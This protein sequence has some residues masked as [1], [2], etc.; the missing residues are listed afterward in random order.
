MSVSRRPGG[1]LLRRAGDRERLP[2]PGEALE[3]PTLDT[4]GLLLLALALA[5]AAWVVPSRRRNLLP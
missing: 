5:L 2:A 3:I 1:P 4:T